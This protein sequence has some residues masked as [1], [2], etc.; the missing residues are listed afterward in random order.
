M[1]KFG[2]TGKSRSIKDPKLGSK[3]GLNKSSSSTRSIASKM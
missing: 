3:T 2:K 1:G